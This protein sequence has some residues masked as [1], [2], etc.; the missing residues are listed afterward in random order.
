MYRVALELGIKGRNIQVDGGTGGP[1]WF[2]IL[3]LRDLQPVE[4]TTIIGKKY[5][6]Y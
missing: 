5:K 2:L 4:I 3:H 1:E 6:G